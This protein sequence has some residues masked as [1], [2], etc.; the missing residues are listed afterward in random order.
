MPQHVQ[1]RKFRVGWKADT[2]L[3]VMASAV[4]LLAEVRA[5]RPFRALS[6]SALIINLDQGPF[7]I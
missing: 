4:G 3:V 5:E 7:T 2:E 1:E 6:R